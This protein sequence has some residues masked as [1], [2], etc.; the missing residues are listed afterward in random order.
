MSASGTTGR[1]R[2]LRNGDLG[3]YRP[4][5][6]SLVLSEQPVVSVQRRD[7]IRFGHGRVIERRFDEVLQ[8]VMATRLAHDRLTDVNDFGRVGPEAVDAEDRERSRL[9]NNFSMPTVLP[10][11]CARARLRNCA[12]PTS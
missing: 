7:A 2:R 6:L 3:C 9:N 4:K 12:W 8:R 10:V 1:Y 5:N 11:I